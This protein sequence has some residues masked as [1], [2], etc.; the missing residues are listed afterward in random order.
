MQGFSDPRLKWSAKLLR[1][2]LDLEHGIT[3]TRV[4]RDTELFRRA[5][6]TSLL[7]PT[8]EISILLG[9]RGPHFSLKCD[10]RVKV[11]FA[12]DD[13]SLVIFRQSTTVGI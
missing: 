8:S 2:A 6:D 9:A 4:G 7:K 3:Q 10:L 13:L 5:S 12:S 1:L 11:S